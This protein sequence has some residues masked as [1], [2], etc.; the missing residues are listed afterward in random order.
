MGKEYRK[1]EGKKLGLKAFLWGFYVVK[2]WQ[3]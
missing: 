2:R 3:G 1:G